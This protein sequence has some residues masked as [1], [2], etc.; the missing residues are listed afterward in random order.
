MHVT[1]S[2]TCITQF[3][4]RNVRI[5]LANRLRYGNGETDKTGEDIMKNWIIVRMND[6]GNVNAC[7]LMLRNARKMTYSV[8]DRMYSRDFQRSSAGE[9]V[10]KTD[11]DDDVATMVNFSHRKSRH[12]KIKVPRNM[13]TLQ[14][15]REKNDK[16]HNRDASFINN[17]AI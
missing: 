6:Y 8:Q 10:R 15:R 13:H 2:E 11:V 14:T 1:R 16:H 5:T 17:C 12:S 7:R 3:P 4:A 9:S